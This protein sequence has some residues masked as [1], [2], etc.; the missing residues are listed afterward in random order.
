MWR[1]RGKR[2]NELKRKSRKWILSEVE[3]LA[4]LNLLRQTSKEERKILWF[5]PR[6]TTIMVKLVRKSNEIK[7]L[8]SAS[9]NTHLCCQGRGL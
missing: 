2:R 4:M 9:D 5:P 6:M 1:F 3:R 8:S 7:W